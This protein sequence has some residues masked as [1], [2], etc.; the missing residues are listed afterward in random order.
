MDHASRFV[1]SGPGPWPLERALEWATEHRFSRV[2]F[3]ADSPANYPST[4][5]P[6]RVRSVRALTRDGGVR[7]G[8]HTSSAVNMAEITP[9]MAAAA[10]Q[11]LRQNFDL[12]QALGCGYVICHGGF[13]FTS[14]REA[15]LTA[16]VERMRRAAEWAGAR[17]LDVYF[18]NHNKEPDEAEIHYLPHDVAETRRFFDAVT[19]PRFKWACNVGHAYLV[20]DGFDGFLDAFGAER[21]GQVRLHD[22][23]GRYEEHLLPGRGIVDFRRAFRRL[24]ALGY[25]GPF[26][27]DFGTP[28][29]RAAWR[30]TFAT[31]LA[32]ESTALSGR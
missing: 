12:A 20:P 22:T 15:R 28:E 14:D 11:Y 7:L 1:F 27:L 13:H 30:D 5:T 2:D 4:F 16:S 31:W 3:N 32:E 21:I 6:E 8:I 9:V 29:D 24:D 17:D 19:A 10:D 23:H 25:S 26:T 18:E